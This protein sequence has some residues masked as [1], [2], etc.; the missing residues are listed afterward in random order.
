MRINIKGKEHIVPGCYV[1]DGKTVKG[2]EQG[3]CGKRGGCRLK[4][5]CLW[6]GFNRHSSMVD[7]HSN[8]PGMR[9]GSPR[10]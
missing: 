5:D 1:V 8:M 9:T 4:I 6:A 2:V 7:V 3:L 10:L